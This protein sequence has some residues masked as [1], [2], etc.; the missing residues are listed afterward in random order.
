[1]SG[2]S[3]FIVIVIVA[4]LPVL[5]FQRILARVEEFDSSIRPETQAVVLRRQAASKE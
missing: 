4:S 5:L 2:S 3:L 1:M